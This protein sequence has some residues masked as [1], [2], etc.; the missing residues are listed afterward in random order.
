MRS[1]AAALSFDVSMNRLSL[2]GAGLK[3]IMM[4][5]GSNRNNSM[6]ATCGY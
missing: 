2:A 3:K 6:N 5:L 1:P 4:N